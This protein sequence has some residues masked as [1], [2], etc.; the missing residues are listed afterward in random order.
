MV[1]GLVR[2]HTIINIAGLITGERKDLMTEKQLQTAITAFL[3]AEG[4]LY[5]K[6]HGGAF[7]TPTDYK[8]LRSNKDGTYSGTFRIK[9][10]QTG[11]PDLIV[12]SNNQRPLLIELKSDI[13]RANGN[14]KLVRKQLEHL[15]YKNY[16]IVKPKHWAD[17][18]SEYRLRK[19]MFDNNPLKWALDSVVKFNEVK[20]R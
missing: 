2:F 4:F 12:F 8:T 1:V 13:G 9:K 7:Y 16:Y 14:Q 11:M 18:R 15:G 3:K 19:R 10:S 20:S 5:I 17:I 6:T